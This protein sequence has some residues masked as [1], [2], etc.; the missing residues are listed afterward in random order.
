[1]NTPLVSNFNNLRTTWEILTE[2]LSLVHEVLRNLDRRLFMI[3]FISLSF[4]LF[5]RNFQNSYL[6]YRH[7][8]KL[9]P[10]ASFQ[11]H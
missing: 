7:I 9:P 10:C 11:S 2:I 5:D 6:K 8:I 3:R 1:M 4:C